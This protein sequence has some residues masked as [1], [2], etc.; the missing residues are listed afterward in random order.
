MKERKIVEENLKYYKNHLE[1]L[2]EERSNK[3]D[4]V[5]KS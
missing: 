5:T 3:L 1:D 4:E 2:V